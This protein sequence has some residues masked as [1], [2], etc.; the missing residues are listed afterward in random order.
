MFDVGALEEDAVDKTD[1]S[2]VSVIGTSVGIDVGA[3][4][5]DVGIDVGADVGIDVGADVGKPLLVVHLNSNAGHC[6]SS[7]HAPYVVARTCG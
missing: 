1:G 6:A 5:G 4:V 2:V 3:D 7:G